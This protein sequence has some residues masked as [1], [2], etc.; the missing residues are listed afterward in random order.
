MAAFL[1]TWAASAQEAL[2]DSLAG[3]AAV[4]AQHQ[5]M[6]SQPWNFKK[7]DFTLTTVPSLGLSWNDNINLVKTGGLDDFILSPFLH[8]DAAYPLTAVNVLTLSVGAGY[9]KYFNHDNYSGVR[10]QSGSAL[11]FDAYVKDFK[12]ELSDRFSV[13]ENSS[14]Q[15]A[16]ALT[17]PN[18]AVQNSAGVTVDWDLQ[19]VTLTLGYSHANYIPIASALSYETSSTESV[20]PRAGL[21]LDPTL[22]VG[23][24]GSGSF[25]TY[26][27]PVLN[28][29]QGY[30]GGVYADWKPGKTGFS[31]SLRGGYAVYLFQQTSRFI[32]AVN[33]STWYADLTATHAITDWLTY[34]VSAGHELRL[35]LQADSVQATYFRPA[36][37]LNI[38]KNLNLGTSLSFEHGSQTSSFLIGNSMETYD[39]VFGTLDLSYPIFKRVSLGLN[40]RLNL[41]SSNFAIREYT[42]NVLGLTATYQLP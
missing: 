36:L 30:S 20:L 38:V 41:R 34:S 29:N 11:V 24:E 21:Q 26:D 19:D 10:V 18:G 2:R 23:I 32:R 8:V 33:Q 3:D 6:M 16:T 7:G 14:G 15:A 42:Q 4:E 28:D 40:Y 35:G 25:T 13:T 9:D 37:H 31:I 12:I 5:R 39:W 22:T 27:Q 1:V 17:G